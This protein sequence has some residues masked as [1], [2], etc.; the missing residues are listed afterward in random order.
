MFE[1]DPT[2]DAFARDLREAAD[3]VPAP[4][5]SAALAAVLAGATPALAYP[6]LADVPSLADARRRRTRVR[7]ALGSV[8]GAAAAMVAVASAGALPD[9]VQEPVARMAEIVGADLPGGDE[10][11]DA[12]PAPASTTPV[13]ASGIDAPPAS[14]TRPE[15]P[16]STAPPVADSPGNSQGHGNSDNLGP[17]NDDGRGEDDDVPP[18]VA[19]EHRP[20]DVDVPVTDKRAPRP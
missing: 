6:D 19:D 15:T 13:P 20:D 5:P 16:A 9:A 17:G 12:R 10:E 4:V 18:P 7:M 3:A 14:V 1:A 2:T 11:D 8:V